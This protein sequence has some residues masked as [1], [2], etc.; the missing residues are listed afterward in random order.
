[1]ATELNK[2]QF[3]VTPEIEPGLKEMKKEF[4]YDKTKSDMIRDLL[5]AGI[6]AF[7]ENDNNKMKE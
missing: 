4:Y 6:R 5:A 3:V 2:I 7:K 1:M